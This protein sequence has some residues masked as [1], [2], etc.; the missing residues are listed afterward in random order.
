MFA[1]SAAALVVMP[2]MM[3]FGF[4][5]L[6][7]FGSALL[8]VSLMGL[9]LAVVFA[10]P[11]WVITCL[12]FLTGVGFSPCS[13]G[14]LLSAQDS[15]DHGRRG[16]VTSGVTFW[17]NFGGALGVGVFGALFNLLTAR[18]LRAVMG[19]RFVP[20]DLLDPEKLR[21]VREGHPELL[22]RAQG[23]ISQGLLWVFV[24]MVLAAVVMVVMSRMISSHRHHVASREEMVGAAA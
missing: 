12:M 20:G 4:R 1:W 23:V 9:V 8:A 7:T 15:V 10:W 14:T 11:L 2:L 21:G 5:R 18:P 22:A 13:M 16:I 17:R 3:K 19:E 6:V 24:G